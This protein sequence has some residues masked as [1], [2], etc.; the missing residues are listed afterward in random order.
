V[1]E[2]KGFH[3]IDLAPGKSSIVEFKLGKEELGFYT[4]AGAFLVEP[5]EFYVSVGSSSIS[6]LSGHFSISPN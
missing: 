3:K 5:G 6:G 2:L 1:K 4:P